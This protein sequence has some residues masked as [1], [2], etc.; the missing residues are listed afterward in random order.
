MEAVKPVT[1]REEIEAS[2]KVVAGLLFLRKNYSLYPEDHSICVNTFDQFQ[3][4][5]EKFLQKYER[6]RLEVQKDQLLFQGE[7]IHADEMEEGTLSFTLFRDGIRWVEVSDGIDTSEIKEF[8]RIL[9]KYKTLPDEPEGDLVTALWEAKFPHIKYDVADISWAAESEMDFTPSHD[10]EGEVDA[11]FLEEEGLD[12]LTEITIGRE[13]LKLTPEEENKILE[14]VRME[15]KKDPTSDYLDALFDSLLEDREKENFEIILE[16]L[17][18]ELRDLLSRRDFDLTLRILQSL[19][20]VLESSSAD[21]P[22][23]VALI[24]DFLLTASSPHSLLPLQSA[25]TD[26]TPDEAEKIRDILILLRPEAIHTLGPILLQTTSLR[27][28]Q[29]LIDVMTK[30]A[31]EDIRPLE[32]LL[33]ETSEENLTQKI[34]HVLG[35]LEGGKPV[36][37]L[38]KMTRHPSAKV[39]YDA[40][41][42]LLVRDSESMKELFSL[43]DEENESLHSLILDHLGASK[44]SLAENLLLD[45]LVKKKYKRTDDDHI[46]AC[47]RAL[48]QCCSARSVPFLRRVLFRH[49]WMPRFWKAAHRRGS[50]IALSEAGIDEARHVLE[51]ASHSL[52]PG[53]RRTARQAIQKELQ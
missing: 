19:H 50:A 5:I 11:S 20:Y 49:G 4:Q 12:I 43:I 2:K 26:A 16:V 39:R 32:S 23:A 40:S 33:A 22:W 53:V 7:V 31:S 14:Y 38:K 44:N 52:Y 3:H 30:M 21:P 24:E 34:V 27:M 28:Q 46:L 10:A 35:N 13:I 8:L 45:Y 42:G 36:Q 25:W 15:E 51:D 37:L 29:V 9:N 6:L 47:F 18:E 48:G 17:E 41:K 1:S